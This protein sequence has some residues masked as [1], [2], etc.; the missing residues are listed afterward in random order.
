MLA[1]ISRPFPTALASFAHYYILLALTPLFF[2]FF[3]HENTFT[4]FLLKFGLE[5]S[6]VFKSILHE[7][8]LC[9]YKVNA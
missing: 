3:S 4:V 7:Q 9:Y 2:F 6:G 5:V 8:V 1:S